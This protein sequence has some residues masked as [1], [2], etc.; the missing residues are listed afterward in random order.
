MK[1]STLLVLRLSQP[2]AA[3]S[4]SSNLTRKVWSPLSS[5]SVVKGL[6]PANR[7]VK[8]IIYVAI[9]IQAWDFDHEKL[10]C[11]VLP[12]RSLACHAGIIN[13]DPD[14]LGLPIIIC[15]KNFELI[16]Y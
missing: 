3:G 9:K 16:H 14:D 5:T 12:A 2:A 4:L 1:K 6:S 11:S 13:L 15:F 10:E 8:L 7:K